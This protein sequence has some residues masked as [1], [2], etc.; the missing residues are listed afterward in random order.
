MRIE[1][2]DWEYVASTDPLHP[3]SAVYEYPGEGGDGAW[4]VWALDG[5]G[6]EEG[7][8]EGS[9]GEAASEVG[10]EDPGSAWEWEHGN[11]EQEDESENIHVRLR[12]R[13]GCEHECEGT[14]QDGGED[15]LEG[16]NEDGLGKMS[17]AQCSD[18]ELRNSQDMDAD[19]ENI[20]KSFWAAVN[21]GL[22]PEIYGL[23]RL[24]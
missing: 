9:G 1:E 21:D 19:V 22:E 13:N 12:G 24:R 5:E 6:E 7:N 15:G 20:V 16:W 8:G 23:E 14:R 3:V 17:A 4:G 11:S 10:F 2:Y 18:A